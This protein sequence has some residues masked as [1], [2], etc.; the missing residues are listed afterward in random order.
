ML[1]MLGTGRRAASLRCTSDR[2]NKY[3]LSSIETKVEDMDYEESRE[4]C[5]MMRISIVYTVYS[6][7]ACPQC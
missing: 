2:S 7:C 6:L 3:R 4:V 1:M 5:C